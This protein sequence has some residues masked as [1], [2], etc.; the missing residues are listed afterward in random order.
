M[1]ERK[2]SAGNGSRVIS[3]SL[4]RF[5]VR[6]SE[7]TSKLT[8][9]RRRDSPGRRGSLQQTRMDDTCKGW[10]HVVL[11]SPRGLP[12]HPSL[13]LRLIVTGNRPVRGMFTQTA[14]AQTLATTLNIH[15]ELEAPDPTASPYPNHSPLPT[16]SFT[17]RT[18]H[19]LATPSCPAH[20]S[21][22]LKMGGPPSATLCMPHKPSSA[23]FHP[24]LIP[25]EYLLV[26]ASRLLVLFF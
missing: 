1:S 21:S 11:G 2:V 25:L 22:A 5:R 6:E 12:C 24:A 14:S 16:A 7:L 8:H 13:Q 26:E 3:I 20:A 9:V 4:L 23:L 15:V 17:V 18:R 10:R 19:M